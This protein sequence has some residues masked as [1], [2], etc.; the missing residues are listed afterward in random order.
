MASAR[1]SLTNWKFL[2]LSS[3]EL[4]GIEP[5]EMFRGY[6]LGRINSSGI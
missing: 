5:R 4:A 2:C 6:E 1:V 3:Y